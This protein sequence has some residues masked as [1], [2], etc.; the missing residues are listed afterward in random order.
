MTQ[1]Q[2]T[3]NAKRIRLEVFRYD[4]GSYDAGG[5]D[6]ACLPSNTIWLINC[7]SFPKSP[8]ILFPPVKM[9]IAGNYY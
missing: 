8:D 3:I 4:G 7:I 9:R 2:E 5:R 6:L 1:K